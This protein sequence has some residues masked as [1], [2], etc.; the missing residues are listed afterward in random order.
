MSKVL[1]IPAV[2]RLGFTTTLTQMP[3]EIGAG[4]GAAEIK[5]GHRFGY[6][7]QRAP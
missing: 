1:R 3:G 2:C 6:V 4:E 7:P 5:I